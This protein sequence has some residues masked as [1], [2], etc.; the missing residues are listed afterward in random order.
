MEG[1]QE[2]LQGFSSQ[3]SKNKQGLD[4]LKPDERRNRRL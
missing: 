2:I 1:H 4:N 3:V